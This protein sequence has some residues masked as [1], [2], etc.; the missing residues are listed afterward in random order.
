MNDLNELLRQSGYAPGS[1]FC[2]CGECG[3]QHVADKR[4]RR[5]LECA[6]KR[7]DH[8][9]ALLA[10]ER[11]KALTV[12]PLEWDD[13]S[14]G[15]W[16]QSGTGAGWEYLIR[17]MGEYFL[18]PFPW[19]PPEHFQTMEEA[20]A[21]AQADYEGRILSAL[22]DAPPCESARRS[23]APARE[24]TV[25]EA[26]AEE[27]LAQKISAEL[28]RARTKFPGKNVTFAALVEEVGELATATFEESSYR[29]EEEAVQVAVMA[30]RMVLDG[31]HCFNEWR[32]EKGLDPL[33]PDA[34]ALSQEGEG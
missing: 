11:R 22:S 31:D 15:K 18:M 10:E 26:T 13:A 20:K 33:D 8:V 21:A 25:R 17:D 1:Y 30:M 27:A 5:C 34:R 3:K 16:S 2:F 32:K 9:A 4:A 24:V 29:V 6:E 28:V 7:V 19:K 14:D 23:D 12:K